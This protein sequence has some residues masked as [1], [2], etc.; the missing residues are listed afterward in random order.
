MGVTGSVSRSV[1]SA[2]LGFCSAGVQ[3]NAITSLIMTPEARAGSIFAFFRTDLP[4]QDDTFSVASTAA[5]VPFGR[6]ANGWVEWKAA[7]SF[8]LKEIQQA[9]EELE[10]CSCLDRCL[11]NTH[12]A[13][14]S[15]VP[16]I[17]QL[18]PGVHKVLCVARGHRKAMFQ[19][20][21]GNHRIA[22]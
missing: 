5:S 11:C 9:E 13:N 6:T 16:R 2:S 15:L 7:D 17:D 21:G 4:L 8:A 10:P 20:G 19:R 1:A 12:L 22:L 18:N 14:G 3:R